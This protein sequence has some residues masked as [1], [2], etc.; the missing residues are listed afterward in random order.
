MKYLKRKDALYFYFFNDFDYMYIQS[1]KN[2]I[3]RIIEKEKVKRVYFDFTKTTFIDSTGIGFVLA[4]YR[5]L[6][7]RKIEL[8]LCNLSKEN[9]II[10]EMSGIFQIIR[11][12]EN[13]VKLG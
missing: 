5:E 11:H 10:F 1:I 4:R 2:E 8:I 12:Q 9:K 3:F 13:E 7:K 6:S